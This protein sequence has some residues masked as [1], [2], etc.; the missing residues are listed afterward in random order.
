MGPELQSACAT[1]GRELRKTGKQGQPQ[2]MGGS[3]KT[4]Q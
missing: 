4:A 3:Q 1:M 2:G